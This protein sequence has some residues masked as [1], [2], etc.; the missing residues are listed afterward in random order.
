MPAPFATLRGRKG[1]VNDGLSFPQEKTDQD[2]ILG[3]PVIARAHSI[4]HTDI[5]VC[6]GFI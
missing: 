1:N 3:I 2:R 5:Q 4:S 6:L